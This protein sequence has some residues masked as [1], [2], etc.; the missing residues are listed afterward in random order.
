MLKWYSFVWYMYTL[1]GDLFRLNKLN[2]LNKLSKLDKLDKLNRYILK[3]EE[4]NSFVIIL[5]EISPRFQP[6]VGFVL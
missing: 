6:E 4:D 2:K 1:I 3:Q 5:L